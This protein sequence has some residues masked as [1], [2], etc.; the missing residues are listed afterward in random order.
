MA[1]LV[2]Q[3][4]L[5]SWLEDCEGLKSGRGFA[6]NQLTFSYSLNESRKGIIAENPKPCR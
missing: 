1:T 3:H 6:L 2:F 4:L 5:R